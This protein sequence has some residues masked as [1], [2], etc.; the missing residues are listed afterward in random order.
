MN[1]LDALIL[2]QDNAGNS[3]MFRVAVDPNNVAAAGL[4]VIRYRSST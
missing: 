2:D 3:G 1:V 4:K